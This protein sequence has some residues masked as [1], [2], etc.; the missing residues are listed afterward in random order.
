MIAL[1]FA[2]ITLSNELY[3]ELS[4]EMLNSSQITLSG[5][6]ISGGQN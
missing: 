2:K 6:G 4:R 3:G 1:Q 5:A